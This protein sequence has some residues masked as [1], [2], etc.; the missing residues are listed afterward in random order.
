MEG[1]DVEGV[2]IDREQSLL[3]EEE[4][5]GF[6]RLPVLAGVGDRVHPEPGRGVDGVQGAEFAARQEVAF[7]VT[8]GA[9]DAALLVGRERVAGPRLAAVVAGEIEVT[10]IEDRGH[11]PLVFEDGDLAIVDDEFVGHAAKEEEG[12]AVGGQEM[13]LGFAQGEFDIE[14]AAVA[15][16]HDEEREPA[17]EVADRD[18]SGEAPVDLGGLARGKLESEEGLPGPRTDAGDV[19]LKDGAPPLVALFPKPV[20]ELA[21][22]VIEAR[23]QVGDGALERV[24]LA[25]T[26][27]R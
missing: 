27:L 22:G 21:G 3:G 23:K 10:R 8:D 24:Q 9:L 19:L 11:A 6:A 4:V 20:M 17:A 25:G 12:V 2:G 1:G 14:A 26:W 15:E 7:D 5:G 18:Q 16:D 13:F